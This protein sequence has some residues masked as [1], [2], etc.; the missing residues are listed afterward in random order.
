[1]LGGSPSCLRFDL[2][3]LWFLVRTVV[4]DAVLVVRKTDDN[5]S[6]LFIPL[7]QESSAERSADW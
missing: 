3:H 2:P 7:S 4:S 5:A 6:H 1:L